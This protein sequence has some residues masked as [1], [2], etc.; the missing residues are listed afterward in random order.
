M[1]LLCNVLTKE[2][3]RSDWVGE[4]SEN[5]CE[6]DANECDENPEWA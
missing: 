3:S 5:E 6:D 2:I 4:D 1:E